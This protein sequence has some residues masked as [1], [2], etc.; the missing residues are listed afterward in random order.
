MF[1]SQLHRRF[2]ISELVAAVV[3]TPFELVGEHLFIV[4]QARDA[5]GQLNF[6]AG[7]CRHGAQVMKD[8][9]RENVA[10]DDGKPRWCHP[11]LWL[12]DDAGDPADAA[13]HGL[14]L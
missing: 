14:G 8:T 1:D 12:F 4:E 11:R 7:A 2:E 10:S 3:T 5:V 9:R 6:A 13:D